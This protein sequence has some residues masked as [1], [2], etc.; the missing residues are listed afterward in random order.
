MVRVVRRGKEVSMSARNPLLS[1]AACAAVSALTCAVPRAA[2][3]ADEPAIINPSSIKWAD[4]PSSFPKGA[5]VA[6]L[7][8]DPGR[9]GPVTLRLMMPANYKVAP[10]THTMDENL[11]VISGTLYLGM[12]EQVDTAKAHALQTGG[13]HHLPGKT[14]HYV[15]TKAPTVV[16]AHLDGPFDIV[17]VNPN[18]D[19]S[20]AAKP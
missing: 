7:Y 5:K 20:K 16:E 10:H 9:A 1:I 14:A 17:Y 4:A 8:G 15:F 2:Q 18:D 19:P 12:G 6:V 11:T 3:A 13:F